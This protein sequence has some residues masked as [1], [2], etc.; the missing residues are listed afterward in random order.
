MNKKTFIYA[1]KTS[2]P[3]MA[4]YIFLGIAYG[5]LLQSHGYGWIWAFLS[6]LLIYAGSMQFVQVDLLTSFRSIPTAILMTV[7][8]NLRMMFYGIP[9]LNKYKNVG[10]I[11]P[12]L[13]F[14]LSDETFAVV[15][16]HKVPEEID[17]RKFYIYFSI[18][19]QIYWIIGSVIGALLGN[20][21]PFNAKGIDFSMTCLFIVIFLDQWKSLKNH[22][23]QILGLGISLISLVLLG[24]KNFLIPSVILIILSM[25]LIK[26][27]FIEEEG[28]DDA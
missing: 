22:K 2:L 16:T 25:F 12:Y 17:D 24:P 5:V 19:N 26:K 8:V 9:M 1:F 20:I 10:N 18:F 14:S 27:N 3:I 4:G 7:L 11:K 6:S 15:S 23:P 28:E 21:I 13:I